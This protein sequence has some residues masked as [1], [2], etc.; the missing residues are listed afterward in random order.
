MYLPVCGCCVVISGVFV[1]SGGLMRWLV[2]CGYCSGWLYRVRVVCFAW[3][4]DLLWVAGL[5]LLMFAVLVLVLLVICVDC[6]YWFPADL[7]LF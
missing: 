6:C 5:G 3:V 1:V 4:F 7:W 2:C